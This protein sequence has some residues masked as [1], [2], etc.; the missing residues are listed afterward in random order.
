MTLA[1]QLDRHTVAAIMCCKDCCDIVRLTLPRLL[2]V[3]EIIIADVSVSTEIRDY[4]AVL[5]PKIK[6]FK[7]K[8]DDFMLRLHALFPE[9]ACDFILWVDTDEFYNDELAEEIL[10]A[11]R[12]PCLYSG[13]SIPQNNFEYGASLGRGE[14][15]LKLFRKDKVSL[16]FKGSA[17]LM[18]IVTGASTCLVNAYN[19]MR[20]PK[21]GVTSV[22]HFRYSA[23]WA[24]RM[25]DKELSNLEI[26]T[27]HGFRLLYHAL[28]RLARIN[29]RFLRSLRANKKNGFAGL[30]FA[31]SEILRVVAEDVSPTEELRMRSGSIERGN[32]G[33]F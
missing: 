10:L 15:W 11:L 33:Y 21:L 23:M 8:Q 18:P 27:I 19:H 22:K 1:H 5:G 29:F 30:C 26:G 3:D 16:P 14:A 12:K 25:T 9:T 17:H 13:F 31:Y 24:S 32:R 6:Y 4:V 20:S 7:M 28:I 2:W